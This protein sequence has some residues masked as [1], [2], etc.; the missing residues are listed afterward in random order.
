M[1]HRSQS[2]WVLATCLL[3][4]SAN[5]FTP[6]PGKDDGDIV[7]C[8]YAKAVVAGIAKCD[9]PSTLVGAVFGGCSNVE[10]SIR[11]DVLHRPSGDLELAQIVIN[12][13]HERLSPQVQGWILDAQ[14]DNN[15]ACHAKPK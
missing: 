14:A 6:P 3:G 4:G 5:A 15:S 10:E 7:V 12:R 2:V 11:Q 8:Y 13:I 1:L 9:P